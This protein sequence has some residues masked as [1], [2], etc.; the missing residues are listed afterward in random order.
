MYHTAAAHFQPL[1]CVIDPA[2]ED[3]WDTIS[4]PTMGRLNY[5]SCPSCYTDQQHISTLLLNFM[6]IKQNTVMVP[7]VSSR[8]AFPT[9]FILRT[10]SLFLYNS[11]DLI[12]VVV[13][14][15]VLLLLRLEVPTFYVA[16]E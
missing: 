15:F 5:S 3:T 4:F 16:T 8:I 6:L 7:L 12:S 2:G 1:S 14:V 9:C 11:V 13:V 10:L